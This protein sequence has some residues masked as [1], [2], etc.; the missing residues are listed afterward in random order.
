M[1]PDIRHPDSPTVRAQ[2][3]IAEF[4]EDDILDDLFDDE[5]SN[6][7]APRTPAARAPSREAP[8]TWELVGDLRRQLAAVATASRVSAAKDRAF[9]DRLRRT[10][11]DAKRRRAETEGL[12]LLN[13]ARA[14]RDRKAYDVRAAL[15]REQTEHEMLIATLRR[16][17]AAFDAGVDAAEQ[18]L[19]TPLLDPRARATVTPSLRDPRPPM[20]TPASAVGAF[21]S[22]R[23]AAS[24]ATQ[25]SGPS[26]LDAFVA[27]VRRAVR[28]A[29][30][31]WAETK[32]HG[33]F[34]MR[35]CVPLRAGSRAGDRGRRRGRRGLLGDGAPGRWDRGGLS[36]LVS[37][38]DDAAGRTVSLVFY[39]VGLDGTGRSR[40]RRG[41][42]VRRARGDQIAK[43][44][45][46]GRLQPLARAQPRSRGRAARASHAL[47]ARTARA[48]ARI[49]ST[50]LSCPTKAA[51][52]APR[53]WS[54]G[55]ASP[56]RRQTIC[57]GKREEERARCSSRAGA[58]RKSP[59]RNFCRADHAGGATPI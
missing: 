3:E 28:I 2:A 24:V 30:T 27:A 54:R 56:P 12:R 20:A 11:L 26:L 19:L 5:S 32:R 57:G 58:A 39:P 22:V 21:R 47:C 53:R 7:P 31:S 50:G 37:A 8:P 29:A 35:G 52:C 10:T 43:R 48:S 42:R 40:R 36:V 51:R 23:C 25:T 4:G 14:D 41:W 17:A 15:V 33:A 9:A 18:V 55:W 49:D 1:V 38:R 16:E 34:A 13:R 6:A 44:V 46:V 45:R 59:Y